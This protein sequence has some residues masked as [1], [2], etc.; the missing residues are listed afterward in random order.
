MPEFVGVGSKS[1]K[2]IHICNFVNIEVIKSTRITHNKLSL[3]ADF[4]LN[5]N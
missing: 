1:T 4:S 2:D 5:A 3:T